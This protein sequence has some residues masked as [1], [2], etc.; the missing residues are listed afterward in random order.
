MRPLGTVWTEMRYREHRAREMGDT[1]RRHERAAIA[2]HIEAIL[3][4]RSGEAWA[5]VQV[6]IGEFV[7]AIG[8]A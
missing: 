4:G 1:I 6:A 7:L 2:R 8:G 3:P 5:R